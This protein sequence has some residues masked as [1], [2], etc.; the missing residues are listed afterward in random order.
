M[1]KFGSCTGVDT[2]NNGKTDEL[3]VCRGSFSQKN[4]YN[5]EE[6]RVLYVY[7]DFRDPAANEEM[8]RILAKPACYMYFCSRQARRGI[9]EAAGIAE[10]FEIIGVFR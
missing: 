1:Y 7:N 4:T 2:Y 9:R 6:K 5:R 10:E 8:H 3:Y